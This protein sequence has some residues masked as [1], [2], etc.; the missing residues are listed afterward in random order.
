MI[1]PQPV[2]EPKRMKFPA[3]PNAK[4]KMKPNDVGSPKKPNLS[5]K[6]SGFQRTLFAPNLVNTQSIAMASGTEQM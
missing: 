6:V 2:N 3:K 4:P 5:C 1:S